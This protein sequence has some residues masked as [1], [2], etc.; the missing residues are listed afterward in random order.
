MGK[1][2]SPVEVAPE[3]PK[4]EVVF[5][6]KQTIESPKAPAAPAPQPAP[7][8]APVSVSEPTAPE[9]PSTVCSDAAQSRSSG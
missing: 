5:G 8:P 4:P 2:D 6:T 7:T 1:K 3:P 9:E